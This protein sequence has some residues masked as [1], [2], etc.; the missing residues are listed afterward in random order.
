MQITPH[1]R[2]SIDAAP[3]QAQRHN[4]EG[5]DL[6]IRDHKENH[7]EFRIS[8]KPREP[9]WGQKYQLGSGTT[10]KYAN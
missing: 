9:V 2:G 4:K 1:E 10:L 6:A 5:C 7:L 3:L 8:V